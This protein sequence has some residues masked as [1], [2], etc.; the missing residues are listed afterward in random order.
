MKKSFLI[1]VTVLITIHISAC[2]SKDLGTATNPVVLEVL[3]P[4]YVGAVINHIENIAKFIE[5][6]TGLKVAIYAPKKNIDYILALSRGNR[7]A[8]VAILN[9][10]GYLFANDEFGATAELITI[11]RGVGGNTIKH[12]CSAIIS[13]NLTSLDEL[14]GKVIAFSDE[15][16]TAGYLIPYFNIKKKGIVPGKTIFAGGYIE[17]IRSLLTGKADAATI[18]TS[19]ESMENEL[20]GRTRLLEEYPDIYTRTRILFKSSPIPNEPVVFRKD[21][22]ANLK[23]KIIDALMKCPEDQICRD[24]LLAINYVVGFEKTDRSEYQE[25][26]SIIKSLEKSTADLIPGGWILK[27][28]N[29]PQ[30][31]SSG[32]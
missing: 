8:D 5:K 25:L 9:D 26:K 11:R 4:S 3:T 16:S 24:S 13:T 15:Y 6:H 12:Y 20:D 14:N 29:S 28:K 22:K 21:L 32:D 23:E 27:I 30:L 31:P 17:A 7:K 10:I 2:Q 1:V 19:C 18:Y